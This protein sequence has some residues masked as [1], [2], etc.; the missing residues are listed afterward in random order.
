MENV[1]HEIYQYIGMFTGILIVVVLTI[2]LFIKLKKDGFF[3]KFADD[4]IV[5]KIGKKSNS[6][7]RCNEEDEDGWFRKNT[8]PNI[9]KSNAWF[10][11][12]Q[13]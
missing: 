5:G 8:F 1:K 12:L 13:R 9:T 10:D 6:Q 7:E 3:K 4:G 2:S 11:S